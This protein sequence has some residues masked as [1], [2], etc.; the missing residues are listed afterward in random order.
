MPSIFRYGRDLHAAESSQSGESAAEAESRADAIRDEVLWPRGSRR[1]RPKCSSLALKR[2]EGLLPHTRGA[3]TDGDHR[4]W[5]RLRADRDMNAAHAKAEAER[6]RKCRSGTV[7][8]ERDASRRALAWLA[9]QGVSCAQAKRGRRREHE[10]NAPA[11]ASR[12]AQYV[13]RL[14]ESARGLIMRCRRLF[15][16]GVHDSRHWARESW[17]GLGI[18]AAQPIC[19][20]SRRTHDDFAS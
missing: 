11:P 17:R 9:E 4:H 5:Q 2:Q 15:E 6:M 14:R 7:V 19:T 16:T 18:L 13:W 1:K 8:V 12:A 10:K 3:H 20:S